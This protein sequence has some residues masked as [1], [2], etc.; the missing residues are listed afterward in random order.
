[1]KEIMKHDG[2][3]RK[4]RGTVMKNREATMKND[5]KKEKPMK[6]YQKKGETMKKYER[7]GK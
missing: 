5:L 4:K 6:H 3:E 1:M 2:K 7:I